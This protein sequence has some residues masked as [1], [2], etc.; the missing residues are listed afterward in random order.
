LGVLERVEVNIEQTAKLTKIPIKVLMR[1]RSREGRSLKNGPPYRKT[2]TPSGELIFSYDRAEVKQ[3]M[4]VR[5][6]L[7]TAGDVGQ[8]LAIDRDDVLAIYGLTTRVAVCD[9]FKGRVLIDNAKNQYI[10]LPES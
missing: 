5:R 2:L 6:C 1:C 8:I 10:W 3:W 4:K 7:I 9:G